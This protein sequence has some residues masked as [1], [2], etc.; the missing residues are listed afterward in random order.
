MDKRSGKLR[1]FTFL[2]FISMENPFTV[3]AP[4]QFGKYQKFLRPLFVLQ[5][6]FAL[7]FILIFSFRKQ[8]AGSP[9]D[10][11]EDSFNT[12]IWISLIIFFVVYPVFGLLF[13]GPFQFIQI[14]EQQFIYRL[15]ILKPKKIDWSEVGSI[16]ISYSHISLSLK[17]GRKKNIEYLD[18]DRS[19]VQDLKEMLKSLAGSKN[20]PIQVAGN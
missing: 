8:H 9:Y 14:D 1:I 19:R 6:I 18:F 10:A 5:I 2:P 7:A 12:F 17:D 16:H 13:S 3:Y 4:N 20:I 15:N 11:P